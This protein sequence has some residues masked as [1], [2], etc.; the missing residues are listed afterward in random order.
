MTTLETIHLS[1]TPHSIR[2]S[3]IQF[4]HQIQTTLT[5]ENFLLWKFQILP[6]LRG[7]GLI[8]FINGTTH[9]TPQTVTDA[10]GAQCI[11]PDF[12]HWHQQDQ[13]ILAWIFDSVSPSLLSQLVQCETLA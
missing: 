8:G 7:H 11:N 10:A 12:Q 1:T 5:Q 3:P 4:S 13:L 6:V 2:S 9:Q